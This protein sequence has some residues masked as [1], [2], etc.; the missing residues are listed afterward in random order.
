MTLAYLQIDI[1]DPVS[2]Q[3]ELK[4]FETTKEFFAKAGRKSLGLAGSLSE[5]DTDSLDL[6]Q[7]SYEANPNWSGKVV[8]SVQSLKAQR[9]S[10]F[11]LK[12]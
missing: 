3:N 8:W 10:K 4:S 7:A 1:G 2:Y 9:F 5:L 12:L 6:L 11:Q